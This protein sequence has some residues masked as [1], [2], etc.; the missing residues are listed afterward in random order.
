MGELSNEGKLV[1]FTGVYRRGGIPVL[2]SPS[3][4]NK[5]LSVWPTALLRVRASCFTRNN[6]TS[7]HSGCIPVHEET[8]RLGM[9]AVLSILFCVKSA[10]ILAVPPLSQLIRDV[11]SSNR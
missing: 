6:L 10:G 2:K 11:R 8:K 4:R 3:W 1:F 7:F 5:Q 9:A